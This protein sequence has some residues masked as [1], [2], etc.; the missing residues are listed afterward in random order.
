MQHHMISI[1][2][3]K[4]NCPCVSCKTEGTFKRKRIQLCLLNPRVKNW[5]GTKASSVIYS[6]VETAKENA[7]NPLRYLT[8]IFER[9]P[10]VGIKDP[11]VM[12]DLLPWSTVLRMV[13]YSKDKVSRVIVRCDA[14][15]RQE[16]PYLFH[17]ISFYSTGKKN[18]ATMFSDSKFE[19]DAGASSK[20]TKESQATESE[21]V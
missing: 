19:R 20:E 10:N 3:V 15:V 8:Y 4:N 18:R 13:G 14:K 6:I 11:T 1:R 9:L 7:L 16:C 5:Y 12:D 2:Q 21:T 17:R